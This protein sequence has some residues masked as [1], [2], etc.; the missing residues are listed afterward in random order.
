MSIRLSQEAGQRYQRL[1]SLIAGNLRQA[2]VSLLYPI[3]KSGKS[4][5]HFCLR[6][7]FHAM[8]LFGVQ[9]YLSVTSGQG[10]AE[11]LSCYELLVAVS[12]RGFSPHSCMVHQHGI[13]SLAPSVC[14]SAACYQLYQVAAT[15]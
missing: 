11:A 2:V 6:I 3:A 5:L 4:T 7:H 12:C 15:L 1:P 10:D 8:S 14:L 9:H 13:S